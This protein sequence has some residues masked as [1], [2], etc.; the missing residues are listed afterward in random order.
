[1]AFERTPL[2]VDRPSWTYRGIGDYFLAS[3]TKTAL[4]LRTL[5]GLL[6]EDVMARAM[7][8]YFVEHRFRHP[9]PDDLRAVLERVSDRDL[10]WF[11]DAV[12]H[13]DATPD[14]AVLAVRQRR[15]GSV[16]GMTWDGGAWREREPA[17]DG[18]VDEA[19]SWR[20]EVE[21]GRLGSLVGP[22]EVEL[23]WSDG[24]VERRWWD[25]VERWVRWSEVS[26][27]RLDRVTVDPDADWALETRRAD[28]HWRRDAAAENRLWW[29]GHALRL[30]GL[31][32]APWS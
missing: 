26:G 27:T 4:A 29:L 19:E 1:M 20:I 31:A 18:S 14:W 22:V 5:E 30:A 16:E 6:G 32:V 10:G 13:G 12:I 28:N 23:G 8:A 25:G 2:T 21:L 9:G 7:R 24:R 3:Y 17:D 11:F 15:I